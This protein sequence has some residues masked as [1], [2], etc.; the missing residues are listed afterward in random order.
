MMSA[1]SLWSEFLNNQ[2]RVAHKW[3]HYIPVYEHHFARFVNRPCLFLEIGCGEGGSL[4]LWKRYL[5]PNAIIV[6]LDVNPA[7]AT[8]AE[9]QVAVRIGD[10]ADEG[11]L[12]SVVDE[13]GGPDVIVDDGSHRMQDVAASFR[14]LYPRMSPTGV[15]VV[16]D[17]HTAYWEEYGGGL[18][19]P[20]SFIEVAKGCVD[21]L[22]AEH[23]RNALPPSEFTATTM[24]MHFYDSM[25]V[26]ERGRHA[27]K[28]RLRTGGGPRLR[29][30][31]LALTLLARA[32]HSMPGPRRGSH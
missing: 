28:Q 21:E 24:S 6:G 14:F 31:Y 19:H 16:E 23:T 26:F 5:G 4:Q 20:D 17:M 1:V 32:R 30:S 8:F 22:N 11:F 7:A 29:A 27:S 12:E 25:V 2:G 13:F 10:Q 15:Y 9:E 18:R 3:A